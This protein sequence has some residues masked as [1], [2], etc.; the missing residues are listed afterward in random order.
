[1]MLALLGPWA[2][3]AS[4][5]WSFATSRIGNVLLAATVAHGVAH[6]REE[7]AWKKSLIAQ[8]VALKA[9]HAEELARETQASSEIAAAATSRVVE[10][11]AAVTSMQH[12][13]DLLKALEP[14]NV[15]S[16]K[17]APCSLDSIFA[18]SVREFDAAGARKTKTSGRSR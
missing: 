10:D 16:L 9:A 7:Y 14:I 17:S 18:N 2:S 11:E 6:F 12:Q 4:S 1:M 15:P 13:I 8:E 3:V 5:V